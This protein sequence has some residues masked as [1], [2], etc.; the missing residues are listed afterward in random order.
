MQF[1]LAKT[2]FFLPNISHCTVF[3]KLCTLNFLKCATILCCCFVTLSTVPGKCNPYPVQF[4]LARCYF[5]FLNQLLERTVLDLQKIWKNGTERYRIALF[6][7]F[8]YSYL[9]VVQYF[10]Y[11]EGTSTVVLSKAHGFSMFHSLTGFL[12]WWIIFHRLDAPQFI[13]PFIYWKTYWLLPDFLRQWIKLIHIFKTHL[14]GTF[15]LG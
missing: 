15:S 12:Y 10:C 2:A 8:F 4:C 1:M 5:F 6:L 11:N 14:R 3:P 7:S 9:A 13:Y